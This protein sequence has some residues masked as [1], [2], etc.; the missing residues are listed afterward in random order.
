VV[1]AAKQIVS[2]PPATPV[3]RVGFFAV[4]E[5]AVI[6]GAIKGDFGHLFGVQANLERGRRGA[7]GTRR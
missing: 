6:R 5:E 3:G 2:V 4:E 7:E 1:N